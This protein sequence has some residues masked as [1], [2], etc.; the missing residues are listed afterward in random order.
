M[1]LKYISYTNSIEEID[2]VADI[3]DNFIAGWSYNLGQIEETRDEVK[4]IK[5]LFTR[6]LEILIHKD[7][8]GCGELESLF[9]GTLEQIFS[10][11]K[12]S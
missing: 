8:L 10:I 5:K 11:I 6:L 4:N 1:K 7:I 9:D 3:V 12:E 2:T